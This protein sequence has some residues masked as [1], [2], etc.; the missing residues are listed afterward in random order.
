MVGVPCE[1]LVQPVV[2]KLLDEPADAARTDMRGRQCASGR[3]G[4]EPHARSLNGAQGTEA[5]GAATM[6]GRAGGVVMDGVA[7]ARVPSV[8]LCAISHYGPGSPF[9]ALKH[10][11]VSSVSTADPNEAA[12]VMH[13]CR[14][15]SCASP[16]S[17]GRSRSTWET[18]KGLRF[19]LARIAL[20]SRSFLAFPVTK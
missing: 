18:R 7:H 19:S 16:W 13:F 1:Q 20:T 3:S 6:R 15:I 12:A 9:S 2:A 4:P 17:S 10:K 14:A 11:L 8:Q 5:G